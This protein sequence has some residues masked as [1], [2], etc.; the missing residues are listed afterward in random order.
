[1]SEQADN[2]KPNPGVETR[3]E[4]SPPRDR[5]PWVERISQ[6]RSDFKEAL[7]QH[8]ADH[9]VKYGMVIYMG[10]GTTNIRVAERIF[11][12]QK[13]SKDPLDLVILT[14]NMGI[15]LDASRLAKEKPELFG[16]T[17]IISTGGT[18]Q[19]SINSVVGPFAAAAIDSHFL[20]P[21][22]VLMGAA[23]LSF[24]PADCRLAYHFVEELESQQALATVKTEERVLICD[25]AKLLSSARWKGPTIV[26][27]LRNTSRCT[28][29]TSCPDESSPQREKELF[30]EAIRSFVKLLDHIA[31]HEKALIAKSELRLRIIGKQSAN[32]VA[33]LCS[34]ECPEGPEDTLRAVGCLPASPSAARRRT[35]RVVHKNSADR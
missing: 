10:P 31:T 14:N 20:S 5:S 25:H 21:H 15:F 13:V 8:V 28:I 7:A 30:A 3:T 35:L 17:Q 6:V 12:S 16:T 32:V 19:P 1:M 29:I 2:S 26:D 23:G 33:E 27:L 4:L 11:R 22:L 18:Y 34:A 24:D 9:F